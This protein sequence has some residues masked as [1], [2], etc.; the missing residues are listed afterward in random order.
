MRTSSQED[1]I[2]ADYNFL[3]SVGGRGRAAM[4]ASLWKPLAAA[5][6]ALKA[7]VCS[8]GGPGLG[9][10]RKGSMLLP[11]VMEEIVAVVQEYAKLVLVQQRTVEHVPAPVPQ[12]LEE[13]VKVARSDPRKRVQQ[14]TVDL[15]LLGRLEETV[16]VVRLAPH[17]RVQQRT[18][19]QNVDVLPFLE[20]VRLFPRER[21]LQRIVEETCE[22][23]KLVPL[24]E[25]IWIDT[26]CDKKYIQNVLSVL[27]ETAYYMTWLWP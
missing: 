10:N 17:E 13:T 19:K 5:E 21:V 16:E 2:E 11:W 9:V 1:F 15:P 14:R 25:K 22:V 6:E 24:Q 3:R 23:V 8:Q 7:Q 18:P 20:E 26:V 27:N 4:W 12:T